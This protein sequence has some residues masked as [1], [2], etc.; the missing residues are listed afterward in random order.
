M[1]EYALITNKGERQYNEDAVAMAISEHLETTTYGFFLSD[2]LGGH[3]NGDVASKL[4]TSYFCAAVENTEEFSLEYIE[5]CFEKAQEMLLREQE[6][7]NCIEGMKTTLVALYV[8]GDKAC[9]GHIGDSRLYFFRQGKNIYQ[10]H[11]HSVPQMMVFNGEI[12]E[13]DIRHHPDRSRL[14]YAF[15]GDWYEHPYEI[16]WLDEEESL[17]SGDMFLLCSDG[18]WEWIEEKEMCKL[19]KKA[20]TIQDALKAMG[21]VVARNGKGKDLDNF[22]AILV[23]YTK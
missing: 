15:G 2:G 23:K 13:K 20:E 10:T 11:D 19:L 1:V 21:E 9:W 5:E 3:G 8:M 16:A 12:E 4:V 7:S 17:E 14:L 6:D 22:S 18:F